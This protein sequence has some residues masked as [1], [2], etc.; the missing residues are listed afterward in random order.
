MPVPMTPDIYWGFVPA[1]ACYAA[2]HLDALLESDL[3][4]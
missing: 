4:S 2:D 3:F 1:R